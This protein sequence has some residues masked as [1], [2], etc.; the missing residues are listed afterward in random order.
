[1]SILYKDNNG[2]TR[3]YSSG[4][5]LIL[6]GVESIGNAVGNITVGNGLK[7]QNNELSSTLNSYS[8][9][10]QVVG[11]WIDGK[12]IYRKVYTFTTSFTLTNSTWYDTGISVTNQK[13]ISCRLL[14]PT[15]EW[16]AMSA[17]DTGNLRLQSCRVNVNTGN[18]NCVI[19]E[20]TKTTD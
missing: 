1:M 11:T 14:G 13:I 4:N 15:N 18:I 6:S 10:E 2:V 8:T 7:M 17:S 3:E 20:Y 12:P 5:S 19:L 9:T 16:I